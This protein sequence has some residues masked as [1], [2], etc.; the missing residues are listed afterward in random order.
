MR[1]LG[2]QEVSGHLE[3]VMESLQTPAGNRLVAGAFSVALEAAPHLRLKGVVGGLQ[4]TVTCPS[5]PAC[6]HPT[7]L[8]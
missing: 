7:V 8:W 1:G 4:A 3:L 2:R 5:I 6:S